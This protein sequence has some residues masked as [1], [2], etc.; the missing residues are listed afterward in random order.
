MYLFFQIR[1]CFHVEPKYNHQLQHLFSLQEVC[2]TNQAIGLKGG[3]RLE[4]LFKPTK[5][6]KIVN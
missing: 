2:E 4:S 1:L 5:T 3:S 6:A